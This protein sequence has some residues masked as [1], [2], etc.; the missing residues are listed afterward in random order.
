MPFCYFHRLSVLLVLLRCCRQL[1]LVA[2]PTPAL[3]AKLLCSHTAT[4]VGA[5]AVAGGLMVG[6]S[7]GWGE[8]AAHSYYKQAWNVIIPQLLLLS[9]SLAQ[10]CQM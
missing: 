7:G 9:G 4:Q 6:P 2:A 1:L 3:A 5:K 8:R 10:L